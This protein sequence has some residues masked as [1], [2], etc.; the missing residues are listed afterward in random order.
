MEL[1]ENMSGMPELSV[2]LTLTLTPIHLQAGM[3]IHFQNDDPEALYYIMK[4][5]IIFTWVC[6]LMQDGIVCFRDL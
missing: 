5:P 3:R 1:F 6:L 4:Y 2:Y